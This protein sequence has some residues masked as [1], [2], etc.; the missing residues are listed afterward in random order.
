MHTQNAS[1]GGG[2]VLGD[3]ENFVFL[4]KFLK[5]LGKKDRNLIISGHIYTIGY[6]WFF[7]SVHLVI[8]TLYWK[9]QNF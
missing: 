1:F 4:G 5:K 8:K 3:W 6:H 7:K 9:L 2:G